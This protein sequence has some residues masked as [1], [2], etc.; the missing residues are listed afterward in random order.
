MGVSPVYGIVKQNN[1]FVWVYIG[2]RQGATFKVDFPPAHKSARPS[3]QEK[4]PMEGISGCGTVLAVE[5]NEA[6]RMLARH[7]LEHCLYDVM[8]ARNGEEGSKVAEK[9]SGSLDLLLANVVM[10]RIGEHGLVI[11]VQLA[12]PWIKVLV[13]FLGVKAWPRI[14]AADE[15]RAYLKARIYATVTISRRFATP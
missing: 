12:R 14:T 10:P 9:H 6:V 5:N 2:S 1:G 15:P 3:P 13:H 8:E 4:A 7:I 11:R